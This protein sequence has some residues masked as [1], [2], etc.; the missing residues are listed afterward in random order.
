MRMQQ[1]LGSRWQLTADSK[2]VRSTSDLLG[3]SGGLFPYPPGLNPSQSQA[4][5]IVDTPVGFEDG[6]QLA[7]MKRNANFDGIYRKLPFGTRL[8]ADSTLSAGN[9]AIAKT[10]ALL[11]AAG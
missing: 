4:S 8:P 11:R 5:S 9:P 2:S 6:I 10:A 1:A 7:A 3:Q